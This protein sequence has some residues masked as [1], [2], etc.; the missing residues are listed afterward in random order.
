MQNKKKIAVISTGNGGQSMA[1]YFAHLGYSVSLYAREKERAEM[2]PKDGVFKL[3]GVVEGNPVVDFISHDMCDVIKDA[4]LIMV[5][6]PTQYHHVVAREMA[7]CLEEGQMIVLNPGRTFGTYV[8]LQTLAEYGCDK[9]VI[10]AEAETFIFACRCAR[11]AE[12]YIHGIKK[13]VRIAAH[14]A[15]DT[16]KVV[17]A[18]SALFPG[19]IESAS[20]TLDTSFSNI[21]MVFHPLPILLNITRVEAKEK[22]L[23]YMQGISPLVANILESLDKERIAVARA[24]GVE[25]QSAYEWLNVHY[26]SEGETLYERIQNTS[27]YENIYAPLD[28]DTRYIY[29]DMLTGCVPFYFAGMSIGADTPI[30]KSAILWASTVY[31]TDFI[32]LGRNDSRINFDQLLKDSAAKS[33]L[34]PQ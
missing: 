24:F 5:T 9:N 16:D 29:E 15:K 13:H 28:I 33:L 32:Q 26:E 6:T 17:E 34:A 12:P 18:V 8:F 30:I 21:G 10:V 31:E 22:F 25:V 1:A 3:R 20:S 11:V 7:D 2:F 4:H 27:A 23:Y 19:F 14:N